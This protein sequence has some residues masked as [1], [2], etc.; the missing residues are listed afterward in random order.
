M[1]C[2]CLIGFVLQCPRC[3][4][5]LD[6]RSLPRAGFFTPP[7]AAATATAAAAP[8][9]ARASSQS[10]SA[11]ATGGLR[12]GGSAGSGAGAADPAAAAPPGMSPFFLGMGPHGPMVGLAGMFPGLG[13]PG[14][15]SH[16]DGSGLPGG[17]EGMFNQFMASLMMGMGPPPPQG[18]TRDE[19]D[20]LPTF[21]YQARHP[22]GS[23][24]T[25]CSICLMDFEVD[26]TLRLLPCLHRY[27]TE[28]VDRWF[29][30]ST[31]CPLCKTPARA[32]G[33][34][35]HHHHH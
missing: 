21:T 34:H 2:F 24:Y 31:L 25:Q 6:V 32:G 8:T 23:D 15:H 22:E 5:V 3:P 19:V 17:M 12:P 4:N 7:A 30:Q 9:A 20:D 28:C 11:A 10:F 1:T 33:E 27:H 26:D 35:A 16:G 18:L 13:V 14:G 29:Q